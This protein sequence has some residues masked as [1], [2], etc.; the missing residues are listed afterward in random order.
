MKILR[1]M[2]TGMFFGLAASYGV[3]TMLAVF[4]KEIMYSGADMIEEFVIAIVLGAVIGLGSLLFQIERLSFF[5]QLII[6]FIYVTICVLIAG[7][8]GSWYSGQS[9][10]SIGGVL[11]SEVI[12]YAFVWLILRIMM[13]RDIDEINREIKRGSGGV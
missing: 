9:P 6:H 7:K 3:L 11:M 2:I 13:Q 12:I 1:M 4:N 10:L 5:T 8:I